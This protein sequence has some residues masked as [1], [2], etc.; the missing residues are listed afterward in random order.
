[1]V[2]N[3]SRAKTTFVFGYQV[4]MNLTIIF[5]IKVK[6]IKQ[7]RSSNCR[8]MH[9]TK[10]VFKALSTMFPPNDSIF[11]LEFHLF[12]YMTGQGNLSCRSVKKPKRTNRYIFYGKKVE[13]TFRF[14]D[15]FIFQRRYIY[16]EKGTIQPQTTKG[17]SYLSKK[18]YR[19]DITRQREDM[20]FIF[21]WQNNI[22][23]TS[24]ARS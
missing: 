13:K 12:K 21:A 23:R 17:V 5:F 19:E 10:D 8:Y 1:M 2:G 4:T 3:S 22:L 14:G 9:H 15:L 16:D 18:V 20:N 24:A 6:L 7:E 11:G